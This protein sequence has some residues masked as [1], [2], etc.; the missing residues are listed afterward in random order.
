MN[1]GKMSKL[2][3]YNYKNIVKSLLESVHEEYVEFEKDLKKTGLNKK[4][5]LFYI[6]KYK[7]DEKLIYINDDLSNAMLP[8]II[9]LL[10]TGTISI[11]S[12]LV[13]DKINGKFCLIN[14]TIELTNNISLLN[15]FVNWIP[16]LF[17]IVIIYILFKGKI[18]KSR[19]KRINE[20]IK[21]KYL[22]KQIELIMND[23][24]EL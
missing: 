3:R 2:G 12:N 8:I 4:Q 15:Y 1:E 6:N 24:K 18:G 17:A 11:F 9:T 19:Q 23:D 16:L 21:I 5:L 10:V 13:S 7:L 20:K 22:E 14:G